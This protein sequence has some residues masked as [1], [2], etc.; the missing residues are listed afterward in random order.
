MAEWDRFDICFAHQ[1]LENDWNLDGMLQERPSNRRRSESTGRQL[2]RMRFYTDIAGGG[3]FGGLESDNEREIYVN[4]L[5]KFG[6]AREVRPD[7]EILD[8][9]REYFVP[10]FVAEHFPQLGK[11]A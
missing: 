1:A 6:L 10:E 8:W 7:D 3:S 9:V 11:I 5:I 4:A 2:H